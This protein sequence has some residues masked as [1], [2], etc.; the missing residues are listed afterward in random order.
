MTQRH[1]D[2]QKVEEF[3]AFEEDINLNIKQLGIGG[4]LKEDLERNMM[5]VKDLLEIIRNPGDTPRLEIERRVHVYILKK[6]AGELVGTIIN[7]IEKT[8]NQNKMREAYAQQQKEAASLETAQEA[9]C[10]L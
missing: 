4:E 7:V 1:F 2:L 5:E 3:N 9:Q 8:M 6:Y 10:E